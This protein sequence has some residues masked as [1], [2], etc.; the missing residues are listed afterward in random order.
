MEPQA[1]ARA[2]RSP[3][4]SR[5]ERD[6][7]S[8]SAPTLLDH[9]PAVASLRKLSAAMN[10]SPRIAAQRALA[11]TM[12]SR[13]GHGGPL[14]RSNPFPIQRVVEQPDIQTPADLS[15]PALKRLIS[16]V[17][18][19]FATLNRNPDIE[20]R[21]LIVSVEQEGGEKYTG[22][23]S[24]IKG[25][26]PA[27]T[28]AI[29]LKSGKTDLEV[30]IQRAFAEV[31]T[32]GELLG[33]LAHEVGVH[34]IPTDFMGIDDKAVSTFAPIRT[35]RKTSKANTPSGGYEFHD[36]PVPAEDEAPASW[37]DKRQHDHLMVVDILRN[38]PAPGEEAPLTRANVYFQ[39]VL[40]IGDT[41]AADKRKTA[42]EIATQTEELIHIY[43]VD[44]ARIIAS[45][46]SRMPPDKHFIAISDL[47][48][49]VF[50]NVVLP[51]RSAHPWIPE[52]RPKANWVTL[53]YSL[54]AFL[55]R[56]RKEKAKEK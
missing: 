56:A 19:L 24:S 18:T 31:A 41:I 3:V 2:E 16:V 4:R 33:M 38:P 48:G 36:W 52:E 14:P 23:A 47:Y 10:E 6:P 8:T 21:K 35:A 51:Y 55:S 7:A 43:L 17:N 54:A 46:D 26:N 30:T 44:I 15:K 39:T 40:N 45:D 53:S 50:N 1:I 29:P 28:R 11:A 42:T 37:D 25:E 34:T 49:E 32:E 13:E 20:I 12:H 27:E 5:T 9:R 22:S